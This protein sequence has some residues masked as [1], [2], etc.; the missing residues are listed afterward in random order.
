[1]ALAGTLGGFLVRS[2][3]ELVWLAV[4]SYT[5]DRRPALFNSDEP[6][7]PAAAEHAVNSAPLVGVSRIAS[8]TKHDAEPGNGSNG[9]N[10]SSKHG[11]LQDAGDLVF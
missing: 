11:A 10:K 6:K 3:V 8:C 2:R 9:A 1:M 5:A 4:P 7:I